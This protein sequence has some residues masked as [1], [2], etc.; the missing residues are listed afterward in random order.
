MLAYTCTVELQLC[1]CPNVMDGI[2]FGLAVGLI[3]GEFREKE[4]EDEQFL[5]SMI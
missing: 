5:F 1:S 3:A 4:R 2:G